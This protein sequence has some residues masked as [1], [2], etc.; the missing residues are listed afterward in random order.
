MG[1]IS[2]SIIS[3]VVAAGCIHAQD[4][5]S[6]TNTAEGGNTGPVSIPTCFLTCT[7]QISPGASCDDVWVHG[8]H[9][10]LALLDG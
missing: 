5:P 8:F 9:G 3:L 2:L 10:I 6:P 4:Y 1:L 7:S